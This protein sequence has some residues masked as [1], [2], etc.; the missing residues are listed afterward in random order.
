MRRTVIAT[1]ILLASI[2][3]STSPAFADS[4]DCHG[5]RDDFGAI[6]CSGQSQH[7][8]VSGGGG[9]EPVRRPNAQGVVLDDRVVQLNEFY[10]DNQQPPG[11]LYDSVCG[12]GSNVPAWQ[13][14]NLCWVATPSPFTD[15]PTPQQV[16]R[17]Y[18]TN[19][20]QR[21]SLPKPTIAMSSPNGVCGVEHSTDLQTPDE[22]IFRA[23]TPQG[24]LV[25]HAYATSFID[26][27]DGKTDVY[28]TTGAPY[29]HSEMRHHWSLKGT[30]SIS[31]ML[32]WTADWTIGD[33]A[34]GTIGGRA[35]TATPLSWQ[36]HDLQAVLN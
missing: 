19:Y 27:G 4:P 10:D 2:G 26:W 15:T 1:L 25:I 11:E 8:D 35:T 3:L 21:V 13:T 17:S 28:S 32:S 7:T 31:A 24:P 14:Q 30:Y 6:D 36:V 22:Y 34:S 23:D 16:A 9:G 5:S 33:I 20:F 18:V 12:V 29:P